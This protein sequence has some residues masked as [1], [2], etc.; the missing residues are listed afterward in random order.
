LETMEDFTGKKHILL[1][2]AMLSSALFL[3]CIQGIPKNAPRQVEAQSSNESQRSGFGSY[4]N[5]GLIA[6]DPK[7]SEVWKQFSKDGRYRVASKENFK[8]S[9][10]K[11]HPYGDGDFNGDH[12]YRDFAAIVVDTTRADASRFGIVIFNSREGRQ[13]YDGPFWLYRESD[14]SR[15]SLGTSSHGPLLVAEH[16]DDGTIKVCVVKWNPHKQKYTCDKAR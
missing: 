3:P 14:L 1:Q 15:A 6:T 16:H 11:Y 5:L 4:P 2:L 8:M 9:E 12:E 10:E 7:A 13:G